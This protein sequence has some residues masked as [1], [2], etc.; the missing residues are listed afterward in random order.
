MA[1]KVS[2]TSKKIAKKF[3]AANKTRKLKIKL[4][5]KN[6]KNKSTSITIPVNPEKISYKANVRF[7]EYDIINTGPANIPSGKELSY[8]GWECFFPGE[9]LRKQPFV[10][11]YTDPHT[12]RNQIE[13]WRKS[14]KKVKVAIS[15]TPINMYCYV[16]TY[17]ESHEGSNGNIY[18]TIEFVSAVD[19]KV[20]TVKKK[21]GK[22]SGKKR[23]SK[24][25]GAKTYTVKKGDCLWNISKKFYK[26]SS[27][28]KKI[29]KANKSTIEKAAKKHGK[30]S[31]NKGHWI[32][33]GTKLKIP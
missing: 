14:G 2:A 26:K 11:K 27:D 20:E 15:T 19:V 31:S 18:Y 25:S 32:Y 29:Y 9:S 6:S 23:N 24:R 30:K 17:E 28:W 10:K 7:Q 3:G 33:P 1:V 8:V 5:G 16:N 21:K 4:S 22:T 12:L 13:Y